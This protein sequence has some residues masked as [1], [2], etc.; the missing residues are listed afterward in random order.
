MSC[1]F[2]LIWIK[3]YL[4]LTGYADWIFVDAVAS[5]CKSNIETN[6]HKYTTHLGGEPGTGRS[7]IVIPV[8]RETTRTLRLTETDGL[9]VNLPTM[10]DDEKEIGT[11][12]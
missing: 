1:N 9:S 12:Q 10:R 7:T 5:F 11:T 3:C 8:A 6:R 2:L 4:A